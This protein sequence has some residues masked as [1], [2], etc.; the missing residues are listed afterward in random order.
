MPKV[1]GL[2]FQSYSTLEY[3]EWHNLLRLLLDLDM[4]LF[5]TTSGIVFA[6]LLYL[7][8]IISRAISLWRVILGASDWQ[9]ATWKRG[10][11]RL[12]LKF[13][14]QTVH[15]VRTDVWWGEYCG[16]IFHDV[17]KLGVTVWNEFQFESVYTERR[18]EKTVACFILSG[19]S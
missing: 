12:T 18:G 3:K 13:I 17:T 14:S 19:K 6:Q 10:N 8:V 1:I 9:I 4:L 7:V 16:V 15:Y 11:N 5:G 2:Y